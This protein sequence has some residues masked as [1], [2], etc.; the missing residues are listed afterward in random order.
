MLKD[1]S[2]VDQYTLNGIWGMWVLHYLIK[3]SL[4]LAFTITIEYIN[5]HLL[6]LNRI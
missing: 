5:L 4:V 3:R 1:I 2:Q 6:K